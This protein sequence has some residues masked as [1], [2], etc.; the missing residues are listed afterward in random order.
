MPRI[1]LEAHNRKKGVIA[2]MMTERQPFWQFWRDCADYILPQRYVWLQSEPEL[3]VTRRNSMILDSTGTSAARTLASGMMNGITSPTRPW[4]KLRFAG[5]DPDQYPEA[6]VW[7][8]DAEKK[9]LRVMA[10]SNFYQSMAILYLDLS[11]FGTASDLIY[12][13]NEKVINCYNPALGEF[14]LGQDY[15]HRVNA[16]ARELKFT[17]EQLVTMFGKENCSPQVQ[18]LWTQ[19]GASRRQK[20]EIIHLIEENFPGD[21]QYGSSAFRYRECYWEKGGEAGMLLRE[22]GYFDFPVIAPRWELTGNDTYGTSPGMDALPDIIQLQHETKKKAQAL[23]KMV[24]PPL[25]ADVSMENKPMA[26][27]PNGVTYVP[28]LTDTSGARPIFT[29]NP[30]LG[31]MSADLAQIQ[32][33]IR[34]TFHNDLFLMI[35][36]L[37]TVRSAT[38]IDAR[39]EEKLILLGPV[40]E[41]FEHEG[42]DPAINRVFG[43]MMRRGMFAPIPES[44]RQVATGLEIQYVSILSTAQSAVGTAPTERLLQVLGNVAPVWPEARLVPNIPELLHDYAVDIGVKAKNIHTRDQVAEMIEGMNQQAQMDQQ[45]QQA[46]AGAQAAKL[47]SETEVGGGANALQRLLGNVV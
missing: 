4:F 37:Q 27:L 16:F 12:E 42:L 33:R 13:S 21:E 31:E 34:E 19:G 22:A 26:L 3:R 15:E 11:V 7:T 45:L 17:V 41:R 24:S 35:S 39:R 47:L 25:L 40:L 2:A 1:S 30:P 18:N 9:M 46:G 10:E 32:A 29:V 8:D 14:Y 28:R 23:D 43:I 20:I 38:E 5:I 6:A 44:L 36:Q